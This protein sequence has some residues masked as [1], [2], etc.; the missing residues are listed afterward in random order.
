MFI[1]KRTKI[2]RAKLCID[3]VGNV[4]D[5]SFKVL[6]CYFQ[7]DQLVKQFP[8]DLVFTSE[9]SSGELQSKYELIGLFHQL[10]VVS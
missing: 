9:T 7:L 4:K 6:E 2:L 8:V 10:E 1:E 3:G 5:E